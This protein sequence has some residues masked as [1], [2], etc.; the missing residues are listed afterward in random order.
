MESHPTRRGRT[1]KGKSKGAEGWRPAQRG[2]KGQGAG[3]PQGG[4]G[5][6]RR[7]WGK[8]QGQGGAPT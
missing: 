5:A 4:Q 6:Y 3:V 1:A 2:Q 8:E 7:F